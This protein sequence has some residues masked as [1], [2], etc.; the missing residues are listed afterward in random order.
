MSKCRA[1]SLRWL[2]LSTFVILMDQLSKYWVSTHLSLYDYHAVSSWFGFT[3]LHNTGAAFSFLSNAGGWQR[4][5]FVIIAVVVSLVLL[6]WIKRCHV[7][8]IIRPV[9][10]ALI[11][12]GALGNLIDRIVHGYVID[13]ILVHYKSWYF[14]AFNLADTA[15][16]IGAVLLILC[17]LFAKK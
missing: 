1:C 12:G 14:P 13:F 9:A 10:V 7:K 16:T 5:I 11:L 4:W 15:I 3:L 8:A 17:A 2:W 6:V